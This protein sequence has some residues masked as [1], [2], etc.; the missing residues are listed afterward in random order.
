MKLVQIAQQGLKNQ[1]VSEQLADVIDPR[2]QQYPTIP[3][4]LLLI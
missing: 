1:L 4:I 3:F 2:K